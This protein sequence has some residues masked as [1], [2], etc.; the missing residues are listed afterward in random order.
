[1]RIFGNAVLLLYL[2][3]SFKVHAAKA[4]EAIYSQFFTSD[5]MRVDLFHTGGTGREI[6]AL[7]R[8]VNDGMWPGSRSQLIDKLN[9]GEYLFEVSVPGKGLIY[10]RGFSSLYHEW[11]TTAESRKTAATFH[12][13]LR[14][15]WPR[16]PVE[17]SISRRDSNNRFKK[18][19][20]FPVDPAS[21]VVNAAI[22]KPSGNPLTLLENGPPA[23]KAD[24]LI[25]GDG[26]TEKDLPA[27]QKD[28]QRL[29][30]VLFR[31]E[32]FASRKS[33][34]NVRALAPAA[35]E[36]GVF[37]PHGNI[38][39]RSPLA[40]Q[41]GVLGLER[42]LLTLDNRTLRD[43]ASSVPYD[44]L[45]LLANDAQYGGGGI[46]NFQ[47]AAAAGS[48]FSPYVFV[49]EFA[50]HF[51][52]LADEY[53][54][55]EV[56]YET[57]P[58]TIRKEPWEPNITALGN[59][60]H[61]KWRELVQPGTPLP[62]PWDKKA[63]EKRS[64]EFQARRREKIAAKAPPAEIDALFEEQKRVETRELSSMRYSGKVGTFEGAGYEAR[65]LYRPAADC[66]MFTRND[67]GFCP[68]CQRAIS[69][70]ID[71]LTH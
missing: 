4:P 40:L 35:Q 11:S 15:P 43:T 62:T 66:I 16:G 30:E 42:Y 37:R 6:F 55:S 17:V 46:F 8:V 3:L 65:G 2:L 29:T 68:V 21:L 32:P 54:T 69:R 33:D 18:V 13:S 49:H 64:R 5:T 27:F 71:Q 20:S 50:H 58:K 53:Y 57:G 44:F 24:I 28:A 39:R 25:L 9:L 52:G 34:F 70:M 48:A 38:A 59:S 41:Y 19:T 67:T 23:T 51:A 26:Y 10:S 14:F 1:M 36:P 61:L 47:A 12:E 45:V 63:F 22:L 7:D 60:A 56:T 31:Y